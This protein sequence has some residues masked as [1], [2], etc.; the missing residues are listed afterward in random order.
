MEFM[1]VNIMV[2]ILNIANNNYKIVYVTEYED[3]QDYTILT[4]DPRVG[5][6]NKD[7]SRSFK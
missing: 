5:Y 4:Y 2:Q 6:L 3:N 1:E 7:L